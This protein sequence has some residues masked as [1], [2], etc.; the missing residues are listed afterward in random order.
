MQLKQTQA[1][2]SSNISYASTV[3]A[4]PNICTVAIQTDPLPAPSTTTASLSTSNLSSPKTTTTTSTKTSTAITSSAP[5]LSAI[6]RTLSK[7]EKI[8]KT[9]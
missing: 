3:R 1:A 5:Y 4:P 9:N 7:D 2:L 8:D 6:S